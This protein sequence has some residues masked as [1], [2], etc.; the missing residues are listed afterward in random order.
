M[1]RWPPDGKDRWSSLV[2]ATEHANLAHAPERFGAIQK[3]YGHTPVYLQAE[4]ADEQL[5]VLPAFLVRS[6]IFGTVVASMLFLDGGGPCGTAGD[7]SHI[8][9]HSL[10]EEAARLGAGSVELR[11]TVEIDVSIPALKDTQVGSA[12]R[13]W[14]RG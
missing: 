14:Q 12:L 8:A 3:A 7:L 13:T 10:I 11:S 6:Q 9:V 1:T 4:D 5:A 2:A